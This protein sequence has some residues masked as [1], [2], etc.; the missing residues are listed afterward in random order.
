MEKIYIAD[1]QSICNAKNQCVG[2]WFA[3]AKNYIALF[4]EK[5]DVVVAGGPVYREEFGKYS[6]L[7]LPK[8]VNDGMGCLSRYLAF[9]LNARYLFNQAQRQ[10]IVMQYGS[11]FSTHIAVLLGYKKSNVYLVEYSTVGIQGLLKQ[12]VWALLK[13]RVCGVIC[14]TEE[15]GEKFSVP[16]CVVPDYIFTGKVF[17]CSSSYYEKKYD[18]CVIGRLNKDKGIIEIINALKGKGCSVLIAGKPD[19]PD[20]YNS[21]LQSANGSSNIKLHLDYLST[22]EYQS[23][24]NQSRYAILN[25]Q[26]E[27]SNRSSGVV[28]DTLF[29]G[30]PVIGNRCSSLQFV[31]DNGLGMVLDNIND[32]DLNLVLNETFYNRCRANIADY[33]KENKKCTEKIASFIKLNNKYSTQI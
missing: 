26:S 25:Y 10:T 32:I 6:Y 17:I 3:L 33:C 18:F 24:L 7:S 12:I 30:L 19:N 20:Y 15:V 13:K 5:C 23:Y 9:Y 16:Y 31:E 1:I 29:A 28:F 2:H 11:P 14:P 21:I 4:K 22:I 8:N 27:Y